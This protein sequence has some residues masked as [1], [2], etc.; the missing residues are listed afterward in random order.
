MSGTDGDD[1]RRV[2]GFSNVSLCVLSVTEEGR[3]RTVED[4][5]VLLN[6]VRRTWDIYGTCGCSRQSGWIGATQGVEAKMRVRN[7]VLTR[8]AMTTLNVCVNEAAEC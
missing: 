7:E 5:F 3:T 2:S 1:D 8:S 4:S 6:I